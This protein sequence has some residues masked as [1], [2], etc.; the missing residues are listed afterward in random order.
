MGW[1]DRPPPSPFT[2]PPL[3]NTC[4]RTSIL[5]VPNGST[6]QLGPS[7]GSQPSSSIKKPSL[8]GQDI[9]H[10]TPSVRKNPIPLPPRA[11]IPSRPLLSPP[12]TVSRHLHDIRLSVPSLDTQPSTVQRRRAHACAVHIYICTSEYTKPAHARWT[13]VSGFMRVLCRPP[14]L[15]IDIYVHTCRSSRTGCTGPSVVTVKDVCRSRGGVM[16]DIHP[17]LTSVSVILQQQ[18]QHQWGESGGE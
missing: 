4:V 8:A 17:F 10:H 5:S 7:I 3:L 11:Q 18:Q 15:P 2:S 13:S 12:S 9:N 14:L 16:P 1:T 6:H